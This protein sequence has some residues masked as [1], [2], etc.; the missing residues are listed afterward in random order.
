MQ[1]TFYSVL[2]LEPR[3]SRDQVEKA[4]RF[5]LELYQEDSLA[6]SSVLEPTE[7]ADQLIRVREAYEVLSDPEKRRAYDEGQG[8]PPPDSPEPQFAALD[9][10][11]PPPQGTFYSVLGIEPGASGDQVERAYRFSLELYREG[12]LATSSVLEPNEAAGQLVRVREAYEVLSDPEKR[13]AYDEGQGFPPPASPEPQPAAPDSGAPELEL[14]AAFPPDRA[15]AAT[16]SDEASATAAIV[17]PRLASLLAP[18]ARA[19]EPFRVLR[20][21]VR[22]LGAERP[23]RCF[24]LVSATAQE[25][26]SAVAVGLAGALAQERDLRVL[27]LEARLRAP[28]LERALGLV[29][30]PGLSEWLAGSGSGPVALRR[31]E[32]W[33]FH[34]LAGGAPTPQPAE[35]L[36]S[37]SMGRL[38]AAARGRFD[39]VLLDC[40][41]VETV[42][43][44]VVLQDLLDGLLL[45]VRARHASRDAIRQALSH[46]KPGTI[47]GV[48]FN[49]RTEILTRW[50]D[51]RRPRPAR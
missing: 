46:L 31:V 36:A 23:F 33:G 3:A 14:F 11:A 2:G 41:P 4:Y 6:T 10:V 51:R 19:F 38:L 48:V 45:V 26:T 20:T 39:F 17:E 16:F 28:A 7:A 47:R 22:T 30:A 32:P 13:R 44:S 50:L 15:D 40:P 34:L 24:G 21:K 35:L 18:G 42:A 49:D 43:D 9:F 8:F 25:G 27:L 1:D 12:S 37:E 5:S 29:P